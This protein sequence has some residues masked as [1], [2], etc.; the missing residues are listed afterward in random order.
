[1][2]EVELEDVPGL[3]II[4]LVHDELEPDERALR[5]RQFADVHLRYFGEYAH[6]I[7]EVSAAVTHWPDDEVIVHP[8]LLLVHDEPVGEY[9][10]H[11]N[12]RRGIVM[13]HHLAMD[14][15]ARRS[16]RDDWR[17][18]A[19]QALQSI[20]RAEARARGRELIGVM[21][22][23]PPEHFRLW[24]PMGFVAV[25][26]AYSEP[27]H[28]RHWSEY[29]APQF[30]PLQAAVRPIDA[31]EQLPLCEVTTA[32]LEAFLIDYYRLP[33][34]HPVVARIFRRAERIA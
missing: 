20:A 33:R 29:G 10:W 28:G 3:R 4:D 8:W 2:R 11:V 14:H 12:L 21:A 24:R 25:P 34:D 17:P 5:I 9:V 26:V 27:Q 16:L 32:A 13:L 23:I 19:T 31:G 30:W 22:E 6:I 18:R 1:M 15:D 7:G